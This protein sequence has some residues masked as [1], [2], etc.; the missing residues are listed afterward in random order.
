M[1]N[2]K[3]GDR[4]EYV[5]GE[6]TRTVWFLGKTGTVCEARAGAIT[7]IFD[8]DARPVVGV[9]PG[10]LRPVN[11]DF[12]ALLDALEM[13]RRGYEPGDEGTLLDPIDCDGLT[14]DEMALE[15]ALKLAGKTMQKES[16]RWRCGDPA[17]IATVAVG[18]ADALIIELAKDLPA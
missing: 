10:N 15:F 11:T 6:K 1:H 13:P 18:L 4:V 7:V 5:G 3:V 8:D 2:F 14:R 12:E 9:L 16:D 17:E